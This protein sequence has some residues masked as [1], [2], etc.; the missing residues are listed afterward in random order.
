MR[1]ASN[2]ETF[3]FRLDPDLKAALARS[4]SDAHMQ[5]AEL[6][7]QLVREHLAQK[8]RQAF[9]IEARRQS[10]SIAQRASQQNPDEAEVLRYMEAALE[11]DDFAAEWKA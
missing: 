8:E 1:R 10:L 6:L 11:C 4:A 5:P 3:T 7:R 2:G 9:E